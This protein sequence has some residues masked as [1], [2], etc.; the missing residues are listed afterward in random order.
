MLCP[1]NPLQL[2]VRLGLFVSPLDGLFPPGFEPLRLGLV[3]L[4]NLLVLHF[5][6]PFRIRYIWPLPTTSYL[7]L[8]AGRPRWKKPLTTYTCGPWQL[9]LFLGPLRYVAAL[10]PIILPSVPLSTMP[11][12][13]LGCSNDKPVFFAS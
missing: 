7:K 2:Y 5:F 8:L 4:Y 10:L 12:D 13:A 9:P 1:P 3:R 6:C 11:L